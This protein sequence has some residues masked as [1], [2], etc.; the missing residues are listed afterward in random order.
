MF[1]AC[2]VPLKGA[3]KLR[4]KLY[5]TL[6]GAEQGLSNLVVQINTEQEAV[7]EHPEIK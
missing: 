6:T 1:S 5:E 7:E 2:K 4:D 3:P